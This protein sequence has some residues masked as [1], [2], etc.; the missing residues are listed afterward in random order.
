MKKLLSILLAALM[1]LSFSAAAFAEN[2]SAT[3]EVDQ[4]P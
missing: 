4:V 1:L 2:V 3:P